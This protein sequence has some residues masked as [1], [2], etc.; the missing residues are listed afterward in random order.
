MQ[1]THAAHPEPVLFYR[2]KDLHNNQ[3]ARRQRQ[4][5]GVVS[6]LSLSLSRQYRRVK[7]R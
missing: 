4:D 3:S 7:Q 5:P 6:A 1:R 2:G